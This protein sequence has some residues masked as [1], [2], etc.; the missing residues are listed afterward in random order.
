MIIGV[1]IPFILIRTLK[2]TF[3]THLLDRKSYIKRDNFDNSTILIV[4]NTNGNVVQCLHEGK[5]F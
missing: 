1:L 2:I 5:V 4:K 3:A